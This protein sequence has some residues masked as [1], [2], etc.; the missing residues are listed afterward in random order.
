MKQEIML[1]K[2]RQA[3]AKQRI[4]E[5]DLEAK[6]LVLVIRTRIDPYESIGRLKT[7]EALA[8]MERL[9]ELVEERRGLERELGEYEDALDV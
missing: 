1:L 7:D 9:H 8:S 2:Q 5:I 3:I 4:K 6:G